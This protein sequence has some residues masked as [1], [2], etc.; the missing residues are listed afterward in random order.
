MCVIPTLDVRSLTAT[1]GE[2]VVILRK[3]AETKLRFHN[4]GKSE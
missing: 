2:E 3:T 4:T 1:C